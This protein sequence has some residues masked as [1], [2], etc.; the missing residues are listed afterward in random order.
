M[1]AREQQSSLGGGKGS[2]G[3]RGIGEWHQE[4]IYLNMMFG[5]LSKELFELV[6]F[7]KAK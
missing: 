6:F 3:M 5:L 7:K 1:D 2:W 4:S